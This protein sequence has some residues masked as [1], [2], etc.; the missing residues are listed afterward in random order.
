MKG[1]SSL[2]ELGTSELWTQ[3]LTDRYAILGGRHHPAWQDLCEALGLKRKLRDLMRPWLARPSAIL[4][5][6][7][8]A[9]AVGNCKGEGVTSGAGL[10]YGGSVFH[11]SLCKIM[12]VTAC[13]MTCIHNVKA[14]GRGFRPIRAGLCSFLDLN[15]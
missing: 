12:H 15:F 9:I 5:G 7:R 1:V 6:D 4:T 11:S 13:Y 3:Y 10:C 14:P 8:L 2:S